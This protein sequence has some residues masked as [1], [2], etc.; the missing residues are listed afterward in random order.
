[1]RK[2]KKPDVKGLKQSAPGQMNQDHLN[3]IPK[4]VLSG[5]RKKMDQI[6]INRPQKFKKY[7]AVYGVVQGVHFRQTFVRKAIE[8]NLIAAAKNDREDFDKVFCYLEGPIKIIENYLKSLV[9]ADQINSQGASIR[10]VEYINDDGPIPE[11]SFFDIHSE[12]INNYS[13]DPTVQIL[14][15]LDKTLY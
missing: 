13:W 1:M 8:L 2:P 9:N 7:F 5:W 11:L 6:S 14:L 4:S 3:P 15:H 10:K 12:N